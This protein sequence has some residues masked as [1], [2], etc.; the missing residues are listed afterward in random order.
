LY[1][2]IDVSVEA[3]AALVVASAGSGKSTAVREYLALRRVAHVRFDAAPE[4]ASPS[5][6]LRGFGAAFGD[7]IPAMRSSGSSVSLRFAADEDDDAALAWA[8]EHLTAIET[9]IVLDQLHHVLAVP[10]IAEF[11]THLI[12]ATVPRLRWILIGRDTGFLPVARWLA[13]G[14]TSL[15]VDDADLRVDFDELRSVVTSMRVPLD[16]RALKQLHARTEGWPL[17]LSV[18]LSAGTSDASESRE[19]LYDSLVDAALQARDAAAQD[20]LFHSALAARFDE[21]LLVRLGYVAQDAIAELT[22]LGFVYDLE[23]GSFAY[24]DPYRR[25][26]LARLDTLD[27]ER[28]ARLIDEAAAA[29]AAVGRWSEGIVLHIRDGDPSRIA[30]ALESRGFDPIDFGETTVVREALAA[31]PD[32]EL[33]ARPLG[34]ALKAA[35][36][37]LDDRFDLAEAWF[38]IALDAAGPALRREIVVR[39]GLELVRREHPDAVELLEDETAREVEKSGLDAALWALMGT[40]YVSARQM[41]DARAAARRALQGLGDVRDP[42]QRAR[43]LHQAAFVALND[44]DFASAKDLA[45][46]ALELAESALNYDVAARALSIL[47]VMAIDVDDDAAAGRRYLHRLAESARKAGSPQL[48]LY[49]TLS[50][51]EL[52]VLAGDVAVIERLDAE[53]R[54]LE[55]FLT[56]VASETLLPAQALRASWDGRFDHAYSLLAPS[57][58]KQFD[59][60]RRAQR[61]AEAAVYDAAAGRRGD[62]THAMLH[63]RKALRKVDP[64]DRWALRTQA[65]LAIGTILLAHEGRARSALAGL[66]VLARRGGPRFGALVEAIRALHARWTTGWHGEPAL[67]ECLDRLEALDLGGVA[68]FLGAI[69][70]PSTD[71]ARFGLLSEAERTVLERVA[72]GAT[73]KEIGAELDRSSQTIDVHIRTICRKLGCSGRRQAV[74]FAI[75]EGLIVERRLPGTKKE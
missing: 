24:H 6:F 7:L 22:A 67:A 48:R 14:I 47:F 17:G 20:R 8:R 29:L 62:A 74:A 39:F 69:P 36:A 2:R 32:E 51:Y 56:P 43:I 1:A 34:L 63:S 75:R 41:D 16:E 33:R 49:A 70:L 4:H 53:L 10:R 66:R 52:E 65:Y 55:V 72:A 25:V 50:V 18:A 64:N 30:D 59:D 21:S 23:G 61:W 31:I 38:H 54:E 28:R 3:P 68:R 26:V 9:T 46:G 44:R 19:A 57:A 13:T 73:S 45:T 60:D 11:L 27:A 15:P 40:A 71:R 12:D 35:L 5:E 58:E 37:S 42:V